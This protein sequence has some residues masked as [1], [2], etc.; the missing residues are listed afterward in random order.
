MDNLS[1]KFLWYSF[2]YYFLEGPD[3]SFR[4]FF[5]GLGIGLLFFRIFSIFLKSTSRK[6][7]AELLDYVGLLGILL[8]FVLLSTIQGIA[9][10]NDP[11]SV[12][13]I[14]FPFFFICMRFF[15]LTFSILMGVLIY[16][17]KSFMFLFKI[18][19]FILLFFF[20]GFSSSFSLF[21]FQ[22]NF[23]LTPLAV[24]MLILFNLLFL[25]EVVSLIMYG[26][27]QKKSLWVNIG[28]LFLFFFLITKSLDLFFHQLQEGITFLILG[29]FLLL[30]G[31]LLEFGRRFI[32]QK[33]IFLSYDTHH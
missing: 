4:L 17:K 15:L 16:Q 3:S 23:R 19:I 18:F 6:R 14:K 24:L 9:L 30:I 2:S 11:F 5:V 29:G 10:L 28:V 21:S 13:G 32:L 12:N 7:I 26:V 25:V 33:W 8:V 31:W 20:I 27:Y 1:K 22:E